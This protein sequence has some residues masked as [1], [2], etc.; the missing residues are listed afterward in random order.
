M[1]EFQRS[2]RLLF[3]K[4]TKQ[5]TE[6]NIFKFSFTLLKCFAFVIRRHLTTFKCLKVLKLSKICLNMIKAMTPKTT[7][8]NICFSMHGHCRFNKDGF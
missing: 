8:Q 1:F 7:D 2:A 4:G 3:K 6:N 5:K